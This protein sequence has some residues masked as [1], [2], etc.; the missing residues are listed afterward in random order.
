K[1]QYDKEIDKKKIMMDEPIKS[2]G[3]SE[4]KVKLHQKVTATLRVKVEEE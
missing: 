4:V 2:F 1:A 3:V